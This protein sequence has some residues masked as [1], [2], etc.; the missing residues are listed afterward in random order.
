MDQ[1]NIAYLIDTLGNPNAGT[2]GQFIQLVQGMK[3]RGHKITVFSLRNSSYLAS[4]ELGV[5]IEI[6]NISKMASP[7]T[8]LKLLKLSYKLKNGRFQIAQTF[9]ND[10]SVISPLFLSLSGCKVVI[11]RRDMGFWYS[12]NLLKILRFNS[13]FIDAVAVNSKAVG[14]ITAI[15]E[16][17]SSTKVR[18]IYNGYSFSQSSMVDVNIPKGPVLGIVANIRPI[19]RMHDAVLALAKLTPSIPDLQLVI[20]GA[21]DPSSLLIQAEKLGVS[22]RLHCV[23]GQECPQHY[24]NRFDIALL[25]SESE[26]FSNAIIEYLQFAKPVVCSNTGGNPEIVSHGVNGY[27]YEVG[28]VDALAEHIERLLNDTALRQRM[29]DSARQSVSE[30]FSM[31]KMLESYEDLYHQLLKGTLQ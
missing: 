19:K 9:F 12:N 13:R 4:G 21:G 2:E 5:T 17:V 10:V 31:H 1:L 16:H 14:D 28:D 27:L 25:C 6:L 30:R 22:R 7:I 15:K 11:S 8:V 20:V 18:V 29:S 23:G 26:G 24:I 3:N